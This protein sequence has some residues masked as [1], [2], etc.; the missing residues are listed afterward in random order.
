MIVSKFDKRRNIQ[1][2]EQ[3]RGFQDFLK[4][5]FIKAVGDQA[6]VS[7]VIQQNYGPVMEMNVPRMEQD[8][9]YRRRDLYQVYAHF[10]SIYRLQQ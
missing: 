9:G 8:M 2:E 10:L 7:T 6:S 1:K 4:R 5:N 3:R